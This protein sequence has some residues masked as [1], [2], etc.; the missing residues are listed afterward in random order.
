MEKESIATSII[1]KIIFNNW[2]E[3]TAPQSLNA[4]MNIGATIHIILSSIK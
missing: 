1:K 3:K 4:R 2:D